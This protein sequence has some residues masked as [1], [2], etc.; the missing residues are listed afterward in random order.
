MNWRLATTSLVEDEER[1]WERMC[2]PPVPFEGL[3]MTD[4]RRVRKSY[5][6]DV[7]VALLLTY[8][9]RGEKKLTR[10]LL[11]FEQ[12]WSGFNFSRSKCSMS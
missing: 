2:G 5:D 8:L 10:T 3:G 7:V 9:N 4:V 6:D 11:D 1:E 12:P